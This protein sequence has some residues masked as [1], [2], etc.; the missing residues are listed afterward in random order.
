[1]QR[2]ESVLVSVKWS[3]LDKRGQITHVF[4]MSPTLLDAPCS[5]HGA[6]AS[7]VSTRVAFVPF[8]IR[9]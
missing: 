7:T 8:D 6:I 9:I 4:P 1:M 2:R 5:L 3:S